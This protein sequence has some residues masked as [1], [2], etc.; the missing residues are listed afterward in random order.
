MNI[1]VT[2]ATGQLGRQLV[3]LLIAQG[4][5]P[6]LLAR[7][8]ARAARLFPGSRIVRGDVL[9]E[10]LGPEAGGAYGEFWHLAGD[11]DLGS[12]RDE[13]VWD[14]NYLGA[15]NAL[16]F[17]RRNRV[18]RLFYAGT[19]YTEKGRN[20]YERSKKAAESLLGSAG[21]PGLTIFKIGILVSPERDAETAPGGALYAYTDHL[22]RTLSRENEKSLRVKGLPGSTLN[23]MHS[24]AAA[25][26]MAAQDRPATYWVTHPAPVILRELADCVSAALGA[27]IRFEPEFS[28][29]R[30]EKLFHRV[31]RPFLPYLRGD[32][33][34]SSLAGLRPLSREFLTKSTAASM[35]LLKL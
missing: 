28:M 22:A 6:T 1:L 11:T 2:G 35:N 19:A 14:T 9:A 32:E 20:A 31:V 4:R 33:F 30:P 24:D 3:P 27:D 16:A 15:A 18:P 23:L 7:D 26:F 29:T 8:P 10:A 13:L 25:G 34:P 5:R 12:T 21:L 17:C